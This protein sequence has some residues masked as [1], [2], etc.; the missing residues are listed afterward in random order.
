M[1]TQPFSKDPVFLLYDGE[2]P[3]CTNAAQYLEIKKA[4][5]TIKLI[6]FR[7]TSEIKKLN[8]PSELNPNRGMVL[9]LNNRPPIQG[10]EAFIEINKTLGKQGLIH[11]ILSHRILAKLVYPCLMWMRKIALYLKGSSPIIPKNDF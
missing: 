9:L 5:P 11:R 10:V 1:T 8:L 4:Y 3:F 2:C 7:D 6:S